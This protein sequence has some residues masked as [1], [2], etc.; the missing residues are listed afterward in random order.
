MN[1]AM[2]CL[3]AAV[4]IVLAPGGSGTLAGEAVG[5]TLNGDVNCSGRIDL[6]DAIFS[7]NHLF[8]GGEEPCPFIEPVGGGPE[9]EALEAQLAEREATIAALRAELTQA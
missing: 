1:K 5:A 9:V 8:L 6:A 7:L 4:L 3:L 2:S